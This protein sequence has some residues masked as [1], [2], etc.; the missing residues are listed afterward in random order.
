MA[1]PSWGMHRSTDYRVLMAVVVGISLLAATSAVLVVVEHLV[2]IALV[3]LGVGWLAIAVRRR[4]LRIRRRLADTA[5]VRPAPPLAGLGEGGQAPPVG[6]SADR[7]ATD[8]AAQAA[9]RTGGTR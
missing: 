7:P 8:P 5:G 6:T 4:E 3:A 2:G 1:G 9:P